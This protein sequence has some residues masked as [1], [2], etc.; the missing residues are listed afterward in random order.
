MSRLCSC[1]AVL[2]AALFAAGSGVE[3]SPFNPYAADEEALPPIAA[4]GTIHWGTFYKSPEL[5]QAYQ[6]LWNLGA[7]RGS[8]KA[9]TV[10][11][12]E[13]K[14]VIDRLPEADFKGVV[15]A[16]SG[17]LAGGMLAFGEADAA[18]VNAEP[19]VA[20]FHPAGVTRFT[21]SGPVPA[22]MLASGMVI[23][24]R[25]EVDARGRSTAA[26]KAFEIV[27]PPPGFTPDEVRPERVETIVG[28]VTAIR[29]NVASVRVDAG[30]LRRLTLTM[31][32]DA[33]AT[34]DAARLDLVGPGDAIEA[35]G[36]LWTGE[37]SMG[38]GT[39]FVSDVLVTKR[40]LDEQRPAAAPGARTVG[41][42]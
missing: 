12:A 39:V 30:K 28:T 11:V 35:K 31:A 32:E 3:A 24:L 38:A 22:S 40:S 29:K 6:R 4:D 14:L 15:R 2:G 5:Q 34:V 19:L 27:T 25:A 21:V 37:G 33:V 7:C 9:I 10:P 42:R 41:A 20:Q 16:A 8:N 18:A 13:N 23:R 1:A 36:R 26:I 17:H